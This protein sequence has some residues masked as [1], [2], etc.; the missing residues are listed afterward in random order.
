MLLLCA[1]A[2]CAGATRDPL[3]ASAEDLKVAAIELAGGSPAAALQ[4]V[5]HVLAVNP[6]AAAAF[7][8]AGEAQAALGQTEAAT[9]SFAQALAIT[10]T[11]L[12]ASLGLARLKLASDPPAA[13][14]AL[15]ALLRPYPGDPRIWTDLGVA[16]DLQSKTNDAQTAYRRAIQL[17]PAGVAA[18]ADLGLSLALAG[19]PREGVALLQPLAAQPQATARLRQDLAVAETLAGNTPA[20]R[21]LLVLDLP[22]DQTASALAAYGNLRLD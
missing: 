17:N 20:A 18:Q 19:R 7:V 15:S 3:G 12:E 22:A 21:S 5:Q 13:A 1:L 9:A 2:S 11:L 16:Y 8:L 6:H 10:P 4:I 14:A